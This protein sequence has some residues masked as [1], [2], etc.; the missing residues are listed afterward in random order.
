MEWTLGVIGIIFLTVGL[1]G[2]AFQMRKIRMSNYQD[3]ELAS[4]NVFVHKNN[5]KWYALIGIGIAC[6]YTAERI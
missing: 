4:P 2:Q 3:G 6:W 5:F 1:I